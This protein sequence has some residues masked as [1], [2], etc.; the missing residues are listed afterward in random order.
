MDNDLSHRPEYLPQMLGTLLSTGADVVIG[1]RYVT[2]ATVA[3]E[4]S[5]HRKVLSRWA[6][7]YVRALLRLGIR[8]V[9]AGF[10]LWRSSALDVVEVASSA[11]TAIT[12]TLR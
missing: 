11:A 5:W 3:R 10:K 12:S 9:T 7:T 1:S 2:A 4:W 6:N 8:D